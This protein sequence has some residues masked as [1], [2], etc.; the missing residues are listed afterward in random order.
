MKSKIKGRLQCAICSKGTQTANSVSFSKQ[1]TSHK[2][3]PNLHSHKMVI[4]GTKMKIKVCTTCK[5]A[6][7]L[8]ERN[9]AAQNQVTLSA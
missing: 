8:A 5:R 6:L 2:R 1:R 4:E 3:K 9:A 7:R